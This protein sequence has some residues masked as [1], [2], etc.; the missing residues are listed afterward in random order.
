MTDQ[1]LRTKVQKAVDHKLSGVQDDPWLAQ[2]VMNRADEEEPVMK[3]K[4]SL[5]VVFVV[6]GILLLGTALA[7]AI[8]TDFFSQVFGNKTR[9]NVE[10]HTETFDNGK[11]GT[12]QVVFPEREFVG[13]DAETAE[14]LIGDQTMSD[15]IT[16]RM[17][18]HTLTV[19]SAVRDENAMVMEMTLEN[20][21]GEKALFYDQLTNEGKGAYFTD[22][23]DIF[24]GIER[25]PEFIWV[26]REN[27]TD[28]CLHLYYYCLFFDRLPDGETPMLAVYSADQP[29]QDAPEDQR[30]E[31]MVPVPA[32]RAVRSVCFA[33]ENGEKAELSPFS[34]KVMLTA[35]Y[36]DDG[37]AM[38]VGFTPD[39][40]IVVP[41]PA[42]LE[43][44]EILYEDADVYTV[45][46]QNR[47]LDNTIYM[48]GGIGTEGMDTS[49][50]LNR[51][52]NTE[53]IKSILINGVEYSLQR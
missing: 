13:V 3:K 51:L 18:D 43:K 31:E 53:K 36:N 5:S 46:D 2:R 11:G 48:C 32:T 6:V 21:K 35:A 37:N 33:G 44:I 19:L 12:Y 45:L 29:L 15:P 16:V 50:L 49:M 41:D 26:D 14:A 38:A 9:Q 34:M 1:E 24:F 20:P 47:N 10:K 4:I 7:A 52:V 23:S 40:M 25:A 39:E 17:N 42:T 30:K 28:T 22:D 8:H 27:S